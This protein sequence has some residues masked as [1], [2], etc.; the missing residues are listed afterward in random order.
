MEKVIA[1]FKIPSK[2][3]S[4]D[5]E[6]C[7][8]LPIFFSQSQFPIPAR[9][10]GSHGNITISDICESKMIDYF[11]QYFRDRNHTAEIFTLK[12]FQNIDSFDADDMQLALDIR[13]VH[14]SPYPD[15]ESAQCV[16]ESYTIL[17]NSL[18][19]G[20]QHH[21]FGISIKFHND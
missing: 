5:C 1:Y 17:D 4:I 20:S 7:Y 12:L 6:P 15:F 2:S 3:I 14:K 9:S 8:P 10:T 21:K 11:L 19:Y 18:N 16:M 13:A